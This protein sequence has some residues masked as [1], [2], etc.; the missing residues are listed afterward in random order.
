MVLCTSIAIDYKQMR[1][2]IIVFFC[3]LSSFVPRVSLTDMIR[4][5]LSTCRNAIPKTFSKKKF[6][7]LSKYL[8]NGLNVSKGTNFVLHVFTQAVNMKAIFK[9]AKNDIDLAFCSLSY[10]FTIKPNIMFLRA[11]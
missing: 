2:K 9:P 4:V 8:I 7:H 10:S 3:A 6:D 1:V 11:T 5:H